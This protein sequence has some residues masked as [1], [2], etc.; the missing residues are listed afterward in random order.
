M[1]FEVGLVK[2]HAS[3]YLHFNYR[4][5][6]K[7]SLGATLPWSTQ[8]TPMT[9]SPITKTLPIQACK[10]WF[11][12]SH[13]QILCNTCA[14]MNVP[15]NYKVLLTTILKLHSPLQWRS[16]HGYSTY[17]HRAMDKFSRPDN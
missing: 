4:E 13:V 3:R 16:R 2:A 8:L 11:S 1:K 10:C 17:R 9:L 15:E 12:G 5:Q 14:Q 6:S 7:N